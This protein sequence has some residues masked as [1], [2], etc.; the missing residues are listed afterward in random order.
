MGAQAAGGQDR[1]VDAAVRGADWR[2]ATVTA[3]GSDGT[4]TA[5]GVVCRRLETYTFPLVGDVIVITQACIGNYVTPGRIDSGSGT[6]WQPYTPAWTGST[7]NPVVGANGALVGRWTRLPNRTAI[8][9]VRLA[10]GSS[11]TYG[12]GTYAFSLPIASAD[13]IVEYSGTARLSAGAT[14]IGQVAVGANSSAVNVTFP[15]AATPANASNMTPTLPATL[16][17]GH[18][19]RF[20]LTYQHA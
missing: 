9:S 20:N 12:S 5:D 15:T 1:A 10:T 2:L 6:G 13:D 14:Y 18:I 4:V 11:T 17:S 19:L 16:A 7:T 3:V 8:V